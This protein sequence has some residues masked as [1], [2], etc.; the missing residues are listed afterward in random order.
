MPKNPT[1]GRPK[2]PKAKFR[3]I[4]I[5]ARLSPDE[6]RLVS[7]AIKRSGLSTSDWMRKALLSMAEKDK[8]V[9]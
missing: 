6:N 7:G 8:P 1:I 4:L 9:S 2:L 3:G 5:Q